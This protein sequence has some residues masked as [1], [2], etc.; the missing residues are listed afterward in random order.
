ME[1]KQ[2]LKEIDVLRVIA[3]FF[4]I[5]QHTLGSYAAKPGTSYVDS[6]ILNFFYVLAKPAVP[7]FIAIT[8]ITLFHN[9]SEDKFDV[10][11]YYKKRIAYIVIPYLIWSIFYLIIDGI[12][13]K[14]LSI[15]FW[16]L[17]SGGARYHLWYLS[18]ILRIYLFFPIIFV[19][20]QR[21]RSS[22]LVFKVGFFVAFSL[23]YWWILKNNDVIT[24]KV[25]LLIFHNPNEFQQKFVERSPILW[26]IYFVT[27]SYIIFG[28]IKF[29][30]LILKFYKLILIGYVPLL[31]WA[32][33]DEIGSK[34]PFPMLNFQYSWQVL[35][36][37]F[38]V[39]SILVFYSLAVY[40]SENIQG[41]YVPV[42]FISEYSFAGYLA[43]VY[44]LDSLA[45]SQR[46]YF[47]I[48]SYLVSGVLLFILTTLVSIYWCYFLSFLP[49]SV[50]IL[51]T[52]K[53]GLSFQQWRQ[54]QQIG[55]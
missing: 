1:K 34:L 43:H 42:R 27:G 16:Q 25:G 32:Y 5:V 55:L 2:R 50:Y 8:A 23:L 38:M 37:S 30:N 11:V 53:K 6:L 48:Q 21:I 20:A 19:L 49:Y 54:S 51:G 31:L 9:Y 29:K 33:Y 46:A 44:I 39:I 12:E 10:V 52:K 13:Y 40:L 14:T 22:H 35:N 4:V 18:M 47:P 7:I 36:I 41:I 15:F 26:S 3:F 24:E 17:L 28:Y 45:N